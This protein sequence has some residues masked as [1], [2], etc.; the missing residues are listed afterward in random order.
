MKKLSLLL[1]LLLLAMASYGQQ[2]PGGCALYWSASFVPLPKPPLQNGKSLQVTLRLKA[3]GLIAYGPLTVDVDSTVI[4]RV[5]SF[6]PWN[7]DVFQLKTDTIHFNIGE[8]TLNVNYLD[9]ECGLYHISQKI[10]IEDEVTQPLP[11]PIDSL[12]NVYPGIHADPF[13]NFYPNPVRDMLHIDGLY[14][15]ESKYEVHIFDISGREMPITGVTR[16]K[17]LLIVPTGNL[18]PGCYSVIVLT[19][20]R[21]T[22]RLIEVLK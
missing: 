1:V 18:P 8:H 5:D 10:T 4:A 19:L 13:L 3:Y 2:K 11:Q 7:Y 14:L 9:G 17:S 20:T 6:S 21:T 12:A 15:A 22:K 16:Y